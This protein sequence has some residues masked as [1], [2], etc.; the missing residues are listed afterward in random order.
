MDDPRRRL[1]VERRVALDVPGHD[2]LALVEQNGKLEIHVPH[3]GQQRQERNGGEKG[4]RNTPHWLESYRFRASR[5]ERSA[6]RASARAV[7]FPAMST[8]PGNVGWRHRLHEI[9]FEA[10][11]PAGKVFDLALLACIV[12]SVVAVILESVAEIRIAWGPALRAVEW[13]FTLLFTVEYVL[14]LCCVGRPLAL[15]RAASSASS[16][17]WRSCPPT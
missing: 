6:G 4:R 2:D 7:Q 10:D 15:R 16:T 13:V 12:A 5:L 1:D 3:E 9:I 17:C 14:R 8:N 11:T